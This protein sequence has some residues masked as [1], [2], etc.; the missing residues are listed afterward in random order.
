MR[1]LILYLSILFMAVPRVSN[2]QDYPSITCYIRY[3]HDAGGN[4]TA[5]FWHCCCLEPGVQ[6]N[7]DS[8]SVW[9]RES[10]MRSLAELT[11]TLLPNPASSQLTVSVDSVL[12]DAKLEIRNINGKLAWDGVLLGMSRIIDLQGFAAGPYLIRLQYGREMLIK[13]FIVQ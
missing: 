12:E 11:L 4:R 7:E 10:E 8:T 5:K 1:A 9:K 2:G 6:N 13:Q 3:D